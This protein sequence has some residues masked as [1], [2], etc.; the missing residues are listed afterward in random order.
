MAIHLPQR[1]YLT[2]AEL[3]ERWSCEPNDIRDLICSGALV[4]SCHVSGERPW[5]EWV[6]DPGAPKPA[7]LVPQLRGL[8]GDGGVYYHQL[9]GWFYARCPV[10]SGPLQCWFYM[11]CTSPT[12]PPEEDDDWPPVADWYYLE[13]KLSS[14]EIERSGVFML[15]EVERYEATAVDPS[16][17]KGEDKPLGTR[18]R[19][20]LLTLVATLCGMAK[21][22]IEN[23]SKAAVTIS[24]EALARGFNLPERTVADKLKQAAEASSARSS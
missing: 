12:D 7:G 14:A 9:N 2:F 6:P 18:E 1:R 20:T 17:S 19:N 4:P 3:Q 10:E 24:S 22:P 15:S 21:V 8:P 13:D 23:P 11:L 16:L 5:A